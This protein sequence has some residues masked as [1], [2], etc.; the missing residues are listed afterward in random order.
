MGVQILA[1]KFVKIW[2][3][4]YWLLKCWYYLTSKW[5]GMKIMGVQFCNEMRQDIK[6]WVSG[7]LGTCK[8][9]VLTQ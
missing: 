7:K 4:L 1:I 2:I 9:C 6:K 3:E 8:L 5:V